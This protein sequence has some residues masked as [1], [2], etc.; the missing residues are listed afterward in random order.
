[1]IQCLNTGL[2]AST[3]DPPAWRSLVPNRVPPFLPGGISR[4]IPS[5]S[6]FD[7]ALQGVTPAISAIPAQSATLHRFHSTTISFA[8]DSLPL[9]ILVYKGLLSTEADK[10]PFIQNGSGAWDITPGTRPAFRF[11]QPFRLWLPSFGQI[12]PGPFASCPTKAGTHTGV[13]IIERLFD[14]ATNQIRAPVCPL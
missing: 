7:L 5:Y 3:A 10:Y 1:L 2:L 13:P 14:L 9:G 11:Y 8:S 6:P 4:I 12:D